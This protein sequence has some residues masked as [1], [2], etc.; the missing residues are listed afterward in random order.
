MGFASDWLTL[1]ELGELIPS[2]NPDALG[3]AIAPEDGGLRS[4]ALRRA[5]LES[6]ARS[7]AKIRR[8][9][10]TEIV[11]R[12]GRVTAVR[13]KRRSSRGIRCGAVVMAAGCWSG[14]IAGLPHPIHVKPIRGQVSAYRWPQHVPPVIVYGGGSYLVAREGEVLAGSTMEDVGFDASVTEAGT[15]QIASGAARVSPALAG[16]QPTRSWAGLRPMTPDGRPMLGVDPDV[17][18][19]WY[20]TGHGRAGILMAAITGELI[21]SLV[22]DAEIEQDLSPLAPERFWT[23]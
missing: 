15:A 23:G 7:G 6:A 8:E 20:A 2:V 5:L 9:R 12:D 3:A 17:P 16:L 18:N 13:T 19:L 11:I 10:A 14:E 4:T 22:V 21:T 1:D